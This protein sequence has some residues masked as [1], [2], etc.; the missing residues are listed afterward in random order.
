MK[1][2]KRLTEAKIQKMIASDPDNPELTDAQ[3]ARARPFRDVFPDLHASIKRSRGRPKVENPKEAVTL[4][5][6]PDTIEKFKA[7]GDDWRARMAKALER[8]KV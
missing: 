8:A 4:R 6:S 3:I 7:T 5:L 2:M 1:K